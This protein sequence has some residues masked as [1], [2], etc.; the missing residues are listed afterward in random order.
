MLQPRQ[1]TQALLGQVTGSVTLDKLAVY[2]EAERAG[3]WSACINFRG[4]QGPAVSTVV[5]ITEPR[6]LLGRHAVTPA[7]VMSTQEA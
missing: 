3:C 2:T 1:D 7:T 4:L 5:T 6:C